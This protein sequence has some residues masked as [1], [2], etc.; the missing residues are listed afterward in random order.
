LLAKPI[1]PRDML[2]RLL[3]LLRTTVGERMTIRMDISDGLWRAKADPVQV[4]AALLNLALNARDAMG[5]GGEIIVSAENTTIDAETT[6][7]MEDL[8]PGDYVTIAITDQG[9]GMSPDVIARAFEPF[10]TT[11]G[12]GAGS[13]LGLSMVLGTMQ[14]MGGTARIYSEPGHGTTVRLYLPRAEDVSAASNRP[15]APVLRTGDEHILV[16]EDNERI[17]A[18]VVVML[19]SL[20]YRVSVADNADA[21]LARW[22]NGERFDLVFTD[23][24]MPGKLGGIDLARELRSR[25][26]AIRILL[27]TGFANSMTVREDT[28]AMQLD[29][30]AKPYRKSELA[31]RLR[32]ALDGA[33]QEA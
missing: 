18:S 3:P 2:Q 24:V 27:T 16:V 11:K 23:M 9:H 17:R 4:E 33:L 1:E 31:A 26:P 10:F 15:A 20:G 5:D 13:G 14:Q 6:H 32:H 30:L 29:I 21:A 8:I 12:V 7:Q 25:D 28:A 22:D 19:E